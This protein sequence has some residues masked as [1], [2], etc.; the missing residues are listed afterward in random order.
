MKPRPY[1]H[2]EKS[3]VGRSVILMV[4]VNIH[5]YR[6]EYINHTV[7]ILSD[8]YNSYGHNN[9]LKKR[10]IDGPDFVCT[11]FDNCGDHNFVG[12]VFENLNFT[13]DQ[14]DMCKKDETCLFDLVVTG[15]LEFARSSLEASEE[16]TKVQDIIS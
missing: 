1:S 3:W 7:S 6:V 15:D 2:M 16:N 9:I 14:I 12:V 8:K 10:Q 4:M 5:L 13:E 11:S